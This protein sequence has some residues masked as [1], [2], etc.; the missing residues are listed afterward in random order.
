MGSLALNTGLKALLAAQ[1]KLETIG[2]NVSNASTPGY[3]RQSLEVGTSPSLWMRGLVQGTGVDA[4]IVRRTVDQLLETRLGS[5]SSLVSRLGARV[6]GLSELEALF[7]SGSAGALDQL[8]KGFFQSL[9]SLSTT[10]EDPLLRSNSVQAAADVG[11]KFQQL[12]RGMDAMAVDTIGRVQGHL[13]RVNQLAESISRLNRQIV[14]QEAAGGPANDL[15]DARGLALAELATLVDTRSIEEANGAV[16]VLVAGQSLVTPVGYK[17][18]EAVGDGRTRIALRVVGSTQEA[19]IQGGEIGGLIQLLQDSLPGMRANADRLAHQ[20]AL[21][22]NRAHSTGVPK[23]GPMRFLVAE[24]PWIDQ[25][26]DGQVSDELLNDSGLPFEVV[27]GA[28]YVNVTDLASGDV[29]AHRV[30]VDAATM[31]TQ[32]FVDALSRIPNLTASI[33]GQGRL[34][35]QADA[36]FGFDFAPRIDAAPDDIQA[37][38]GGKASLGSATAEPFALAVGDTLDLTGPLGNF[39]V[40]FQP[41]QFQ[42]MGQA[43]A[44]EIAAALNADASFQANGLIASAVDGSLFVQT[45]GAGASESFTIQGG[46]A[47]AVLGWGAGTNVV[48]SNLSVAPR[49]SGNYGGDAN[50]RWIFRPSAD[51][52]IGATPGLKIDV[53]DA[54]G[55]R[56]AQ[57]DVGANYVPGTEI[58]I[59]DGVKVAFGLGDVSATDHD[60]FGVHLLADSDTSDVLAAVGLNTLFVGHDAAT[61]GVRQ[62]L[63]DDPSLLAAGLGTAS[64][65][66]R[67][68]VRMLSIGD[69]GL[70]ALDGLSF[71]G[72]LAQAVGDVALELSSARDASESETFLQQSLESRRDQISGVNVDEELAHMIEAQQAYSAAGEYLRVVSELTNELLNI[73]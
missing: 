25:D 68:L 63:I 28:L 29:V 19:A 33:D 8:F 45:L 58:E 16:R 73:L 56:I 27:D 30:D 46:S 36:G 69:S 9:S 65:D 26:G 47:A 6:G 40:A 32:E 72:H 14:E 35:V 24:N 70:A 3:S 67:N 23:D 49:L 20:F 1:S 10:P 21:E 43:T 11:S 64:G 52:T 15:R 54:A 50:A 22:M 13:K 59:K 37:F 66:G 39:T 53:F 12:A 5:Q 2:H 57:L 55:S 51:G 48:G 17:Q 31:R 7:R 62:A 44:A 61:L 41:Q 60:Q 18:M 42:Q 34:Q 71:E 4:Q 38:G